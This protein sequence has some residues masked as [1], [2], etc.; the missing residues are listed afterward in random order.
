MRLVLDTNILIAAFLKVSVSRALLLH[1]ALEFLLPEY[2][3]E[4]IFRHKAMLCRRIGLL[5]EAFD[6][7]LQLLLDRTVIVPA[8]EI[9]PYLHQA[10]FLMGARDPDD[11]PFVALALARENQG[12]WSNDKDFDRLGHIKIWKTSDLLEYVK[13]R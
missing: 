2:A 9:R 3:M 10:R 6:L 11:L 4:E 5:P 8:D 13:R 12:I 7:L 1:P